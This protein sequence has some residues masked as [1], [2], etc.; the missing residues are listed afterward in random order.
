MQ[1]SPT[2][3]ATINKKVFCK[4]RR[5]CFFCLALAE[6]DSHG[7]AKSS[8]KICAATAKQVL[9]NCFCK[10]DQKCI[11]L[12]R[13]WLDPSHPVAGKQ[14]H[15]RLI[16]PWRCCCVYFFSCGLFCIMWFSCLGLMRF[17]LFGVIYATCNFLLTKRK[18]LETISLLFGMCNCNFIC[19]RKAPHSYVN[20]NFCLEM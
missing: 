1:G 5:C 16:L 10:T 2:A 17:R 15:L 7:L 9:K 13:L 19:N 6:R 18:Q 11:L 4:D 8:S 12:L 14:R 3:T 20:M